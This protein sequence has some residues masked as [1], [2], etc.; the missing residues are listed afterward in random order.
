MKL[1]PPRNQTWFLA[2]LLALLGIVAHVIVDIPFVTPYAFWLVT[3]AF[4][5][6]FLGALLPGI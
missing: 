6:L 1:S 2:T 5:L 4:I 3:L